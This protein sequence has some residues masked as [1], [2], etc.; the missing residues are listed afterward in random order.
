MRSVGWALAQHHQRC[1]A[2]A[3]PTLR[4]LSLTFLAFTLLGCGFHLRGTMDVPLWLKQVTIINEHVDRETALDLAKQLDALSIKV[5]DN[6]KLA[7]YII[8]LKQDNFSRDLLSVSASNGPRQY[9][10]S[11]HLNYFYQAS[12]SKKMSPPQTVVVERIYT[13]NSNTM[14]GSSYEQQQ[15]VKT[16]HLSAV[17]HMLARINAYHLATHE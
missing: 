14:L 3:Q 1:W 16:M 12:H 11:Y 10:L 2:K 4:L 5:T 17:Q 13:E 6:P 15:F 7:Q 8:I 9:K